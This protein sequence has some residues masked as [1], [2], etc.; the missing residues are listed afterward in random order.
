MPSLRLLAARP[1]YHPAPRPVRIGTL[2]IVVA[3][4]PSATGMA[5]LIK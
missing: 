3:A 5:G 1:E 4:L 2:L